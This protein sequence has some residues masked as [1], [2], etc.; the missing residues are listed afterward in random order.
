MKLHEYQSAKLLAGYGIPVPRGE[1]VRDPGDAADLIEGFDGSGV[2]KAQV[3]TGGRGKAGG[4]KVVHS[5]KEA[6]DAARMIL[7]MTI[8]GYQV[9]MVLVNEAADIGKEFYVSIVVNRNTKKAECLFSPSGGVD[10]EETADISPE[11]I[12]HIPVDPI[13]GIDDALL[14]REIK[15]YFDTPELFD[16]ARKI[17]IN[18]VRL[19]QEKDCSLVEINPLAQTR[20]GDL[21]AVDA[22]IVI[23]DN[24]LFRHP[25]IAALQNPEEYSRD[26][27][28]ARKASLS[29]VS[30]DGTIGC[31]VNGA[32]LAMAT[33]DL[34]KY[35]GAE[36]AN[37]L[38][39]GGSSN[40]QKVVDALTI[41][42]RNPKI[43]AILMNVFGGITRCDDVARGV[44]MA[45][46]MIDI[47]VPFV[48]RL[49][50]TNGDLGR[51]MLEDEGFHA[52]NDLN[53]AVMKVIE[54]SGKAR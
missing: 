28:D 44:I 18:M 25:D 40:P 50:G 43:S 34:I 14:K 12:R 27:I 42:L 24:A 4:V 46:D 52:Y 16:T 19:F 15:E 17:I 11:K 6:A 8:R 48:I 38:D 31:M 37:F 29:F 1:V 20:G 41:L 2:I 35:Y 21:I 5:G 9:D 22:K 53:E 51:K 13:S 30:L 45:R 49:I 32:G 3:L 7:G 36:P 26:E 23:D 10:I 47:N 33:M 54:A 39:I